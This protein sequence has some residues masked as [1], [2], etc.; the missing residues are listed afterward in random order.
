MAPV[1]VASAVVVVAEDE[2]DD[3]DGGDAP[4]RCRV[5]DNMLWMSSNSVSVSMMVVGTVDRWPSNLEPKKL[6]D[7]I[8]LGGS[9]HSHFF[10]AIVPPGRRSRLKQQ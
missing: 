4:P 1:V 5:L 7:Q 10:P 3:D 2:D 8:K 9:M 6:D